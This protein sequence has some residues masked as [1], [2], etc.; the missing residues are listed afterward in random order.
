MER[1]ESQ[2][3]GSSSPSLLSSILYPL[4]KLTIL[5][6]LLTGL[7]LVFTT[8]SAGVTPIDKVAEII[9]DAMPPAVEEAVAEAVEAVK[10]VVSETPSPAAEVL[11]EQPS[12][13]DV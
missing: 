9:K 4:L 13:A 6:V 7:Y 2:G 8:P 12:V 11:P 1:T 10:E 5:A 3:P